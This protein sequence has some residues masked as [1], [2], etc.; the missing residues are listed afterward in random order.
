[1]PKCE[2]EGPEVLIRE[3]PEELTLRAE[4]VGTQKLC[5][6]VDHT[7]QDRWGPPWWMLIGMHSATRRWALALDVRLDGSRT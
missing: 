5:V 7:W 6:N 4:E 1:M 2:E 3:G